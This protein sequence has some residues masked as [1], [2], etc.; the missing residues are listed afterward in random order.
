MNHLP[1]NFLWFHQ[2]LVSEKKA[3]VE[4][5]SSINIRLYH[6]VIVAQVSEPI[7]G[8]NFLIEYK[9]DL[10]WN[11]PLA[12]QARSNCLVPHTRQAETIGWVLGGNCLL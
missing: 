9:L 2:Y 8:F 4:S 5:A 7:V 1:E 6:N 3:T 10:K 11:H 12:S